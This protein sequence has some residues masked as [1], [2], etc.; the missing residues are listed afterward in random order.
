MKWYLLFQLPPNRVSNQFYFFLQDRSLKKQIKITKHQKKVLL[1]FLEGNFEYSRGAFK[2][3]AN[4]VS[5]D[6]NLI[7]EEITARLN[8]IGPMKTSSMWRK[9]CADLRMQIKKKVLEEKELTDED[10]RMAK[11]YGLRSDPLDRSSRLVNDRVTSA[12]KTKMVDLIRENFWFNQN[13]IKLEPKSHCMDWEEIADQLNQLGGCIKSTIAWRKCWSDIKCDVG[14]KF[15]NGSVPKM[16]TEDEYK[17]ATHYGWLSGEQVT[18]SNSESFYQNP[19]STSPV[20]YVIDPTIIIK[21]EGTSE[22][23]VQD[24]GLIQEEN[25]DFVVERLEDDEPDADTNSVDDDRSMNPV[26]VMEDVPIPDDTNTR[27]V[28]MTPVATQTTS[29]DTTKSLQDSLLEQ[30]LAAQLRTNTL[31][32]QLLEKNTDNNNVQN[33]IL[34][35]LKNNSFMMVNR[36]FPK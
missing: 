13:T 11:F 1:D 21:S 18:T 28:F 27:T 12:Q 29:D 9:T 7:W 26:E 22:Q 36:A 31:L 33:G 8:G 5:D 23:G 34:N 20:Q 10:K 17:I 24:E 16:L 35:E 30:I 19:V 25:E 32:E 14:K 15:M 6:K 2:L 3:L 4:S